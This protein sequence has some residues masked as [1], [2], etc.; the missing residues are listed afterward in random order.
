MSYFIEINALLFN[1]FRR[2]QTVIVGL[3]H[4]IRDTE[5]GRERSMYTATVK[6]ELLLDLATLPMADG[7]VMN[8]V[9]LFAPCLLCFYRILKATFENSIWWPFQQ[10]A[11]PIAL[12]LWKPI[13]SRHLVMMTSIIYQ[14]LE[15]WC[16]QMVLRS[17]FCLNMVSVTIISNSEHKTSRSSPLELHFPIPCLPMPRATCHFVFIFSHCSMLSAVAYV[18]EGCHWAHLP[19]GCRTPPCFHLGSSLLVRTRW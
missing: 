3:C 7:T 14:C 1:V 12:V 9:S 8:L 13:L 5:W 15:R 16:I 4:C 17:S 18:Y 19:A 6:S 2:A 11:S 10:L